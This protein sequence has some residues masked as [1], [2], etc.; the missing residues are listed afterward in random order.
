MDVVRLTLTNAGT[1]EKRNMSGHFREVTSNIPTAL[2][3]S[4][5]VRP[6]PFRCVPSFH[7]CGHNNNNNASGVTQKQC[8]TEVDDTSMRAQLKQRKLRAKFPFR[9]RLG[10]GLQLVDLL[11][12]LHSESIPGGFVVHRYVQNDTT[13]GWSRILRNGHVLGGEGALLSF[14]R[15]LLRSQPQLP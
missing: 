2:S 9:R 11:S 10:Y 7:F 1:Q 4:S 12:Y 3:T 14:S 8:G 15:K 13:D 5:F 6:F